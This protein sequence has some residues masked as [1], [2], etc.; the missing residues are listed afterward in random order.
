MISNIFYYLYFSVV[1][2]WII[3]AWLPIK[4]RND[5]LY[6]YVTV[7]ILTSVLVLRDVEYG[8]IDMLRYERWYEGMQYVSNLKEALYFANGKD[9]GYWFF[10]YLFFLLGFSFQQFVVVITI[11]VMTIYAFYIKKYSPNFL[12]SHLFFMG[13]GAYTFMFY[14]LRQS[15]ALGVVLLCIDA[16]YKKEII[17]MVLFA[18]VA[19]LFHWSSIV[20]IPFLIASKFKFNRIVV[21]LYFSVIL[22]SLFFS[23]Q[24]GYLIAL[25]FRDEYATEE[26][27]STQSIGG[28]TIM[29]LLF[30]FWYFVVV[31]RVVNTNYKV[32]FFTHGFLIL[33]IIQMCSAYAYVFTRLNFFF[34]FSIFTI[35]VPMSFDKKY[36]GLILK[37]TKFLSVSITSILVVLMFFLFKIYI[38][39]NRLQNYVF[40]WELA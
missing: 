4:K 37:E 10:N 34:M 5:N 20:V 23:A 1:V 39:G 17:K 2:L 19:F 14:G 21:S 31:H 12:L 13:C 25:L 3:N 18:I 35:A 6:L 16:C 33:I 36:L 11:F 15:I 7:I 29:F 9:A 24:F 26:V 22:L 32:R 30:F 28:L 40:F 8:V 38:V 27:M